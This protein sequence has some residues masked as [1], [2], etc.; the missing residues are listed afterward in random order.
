MNNDPTPPRRRIYLGAPLQIALGYLLFASL[1]IVFSDRVVAAI[2]EDAAHLHRL[3]TYKGLFFVTFTA[4]LLWAIIAYWSHRRHESERHA[5]E[6]NRKLADR[7][8][9]L[10]TILNVIPVGVGVSHDPDC[11][12]IRLNPRFLET[13]GLPA[14]EGF[15]ISK[16]VPAEQQPPYRC[17]RDGRELAADELP[18]QI[19]ARTGRTV[20][21]AELD[22]EIENGGRFH[23]L[24]NAAPLFDDTGKVRGCVGA[25]LDITQRTRAEEALRRS[26]EQ[27]R[28]LVEGAR[29]IAWEVDLATMQFTFVSRHAE[30]VLGYPVEKW[31]EHDFWPRHI[32]PDD[33]EWAVEFCKT[34]TERGTDHVFEYRMIRADGAVVWLRDLVSV[35]ESGGRPTMLRGVM[36]DITQKKEF[37]LALR[38]SEEQLRLIADSLP[39]L[40]GYVDEGLRY[41]FVNRAHEEWYGVSRERIAGMRMRDLL[42]DDLYRRVMPHAESALRG[43]WSSFDG[44][45]PDQSGTER[46]IAAQYI[47]HRD[48]SGR[49]VGLFVMVQDITA[50][51]RAERELREANAKLEAIILASPLAIVAMDDR[52]NVTM[53][54]PGAE[55]IFGWSRAEVLGKPLRVVPES[56]Q[57]Q[58][59]RLMARLTNGESLD[60]VEVRRRRK[61]G[62][63]FDAALYIA[64]LRSADARIAGVVGVVADITERKR[65]E[66]A[67]RESERTLKTLISNLPGVAYRCQNDREWTME[68]VSEG[69]EEL[70]GYPPSAFT[71][72]REV[73]IG[74]LTH[75]ADRE[76]VWESVQ[77]ALRQRRPFEVDYRVRTRDGAEKWCWERGTGVYD[78]NG[79]VVAIEGF[80]TDATESKRAQRLQSLMLAE[81]DHRVKNNLAAVLSIAEQSARVAGS[82]EEFHSAFTGRVRALARMHSALTRGKWQG[83]E[84]RDLV[85]QTLEAYM[86]TG[87]G[88]V[89]AEGEKAVLPARAA[90]PVCMALHELATNAAKYGALSVPDGRVDVSWRVED[91]RDGPGAAKR[92]VLTWTESRGPPVSPPE[93][94]GFGLELIEGGIAYELRGHVDLQFPESGVVCKM[95]IPMTEDD[96]DKSDA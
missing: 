28:R 76:P 73:S 35:I 15:N 36:V 6:L 93:K 65:A 71:E 11:R 50:I 5:E 91:S 21:N 79:G 39:V 54:N 45:V 1:W 59:E 27:H 60:G 74:R 22:V 86:L 94:R 25:F 58:F 37:E 92:I 75:E 13:V 67:L 90:S 14:D 57:A 53:W 18:M 40:I 48:D 87:G 95:D 30:A 69:I 20:L 46:H 29:I 32:H 84:V 78:E 83:V 49:T 3:Q 66:N 56:E 23:L 8:G 72:T 42:G 26:E 19:A 10:Q 9:E 51:K 80:I 82:L 2:V 77:S 16:S 88:R 41:E 81:L 61:D 44:V 33:R 4:M 31:Y 47:P 89:Y 85:D 64:P 68:F 55:Q 52:A 24:A 62:S 7:V 63:E 96:D 12:D 34:E 70:T 17:F 43:E 38:R